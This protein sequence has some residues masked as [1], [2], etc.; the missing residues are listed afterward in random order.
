M[1][2]IDFEMKV[3]KEL[4][5]QGKTITT[6]AKELGI[7][8]A[9]CSDVIRGNRQGIKVKENLTSIC[10]CKQAGGFYRIGISEF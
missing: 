10:R 6:L 1:K 3:K 4:R 5:K 9:Y 8:V 2:K 7:S